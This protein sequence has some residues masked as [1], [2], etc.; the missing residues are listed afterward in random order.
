[1]STIRFPADF[2]W[3]TATSAYQIEGAVREDGRGETIWDRFCATP[4][5]IFEGHTGEVA[6]DHYHRFRE[7]VAL[8]RE[9]G[10]RSYRFSVAWARVFP[11]GGGRLNPAGLDFYQRLV[12]ELAGA[13]ITPM[14]TLYHWDLPQALQDHGGWEARDT[15]RY[16]ADYAAALFQ[17]LGDRIKLWITHNE[18]Y[19]AAFIG[20]GTGEH[21]PG[22]RGQAKAV[23]VA[24]HLLLSHALAVQAYRERKGAGGK[25]GI[26]LDL[27]PVLAASDHPEDRQ[28]ATLYDARQNRWFLDPVFLGRYPPDLLEILRRRNEA[29]RHPEEDLQT[30]A[31]SPVDFLGVN[32]YF[33]QLVRRPE[34]KGDLFAPVRPDYP[35]V[36]FTEMGWEEWPD[37]LYELLKRLDREY[38]QPELYVTENGAA[39]PDERMADGR[40]DDQDRVS[41]LREHFAAAAKALAEGVRLK[42]YQIWSLLD[43]FEWAFGYSKRFGLVHVD[44]QTLRRTPKQ[45]ALWY[46]R[47]IAEGGL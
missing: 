15:A 22:I 37:G 8:M 17:R 20:Y 6:C 43:N 36:H 38:G 24:H 32:Y 27:H 25:I 42:G 18:P 3:G 45:S 39:C 33:R 26:S 2:L 4:G 12:D 19:V 30:F 13:G 44:R 34:R 47:L 28:A 7:D 41:Y 5:K 1:M 46:R 31:A 16:F 35:G 10:L 11:A 29:P 21:A 23:Q 9:L 14:A 40:V